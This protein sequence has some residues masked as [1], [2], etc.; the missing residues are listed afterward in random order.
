MF[1]SNV[2]VLPNN[3]SHFHAIIIEYETV[4]DE[5]DEGITTEC[6]VNFKLAP[7]AG[8]RV[9]SNSV[10]PLTPFDGKVEGLY[11]EKTGN[12]TYMPHLRFS[13][14]HFSSEHE[15]KEDFLEMVNQKGFFI[16]KPE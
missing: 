7:I 9:T 15:T 4:E 1:D 8:W 13:F 5:Y 16:T 10:I 6:A 2:N 14:N 12:Y 3:L 11:S